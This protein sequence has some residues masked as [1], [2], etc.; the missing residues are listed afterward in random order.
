MVYMIK[1]NVR[2]YD[3][4]IMQWNW[5]IKNILNENQVVRKQKVMQIWFPNNINLIILLRHYHE[6]HAKQVLFLNSV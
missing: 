5:E 3:Q 2:G 4:F 6:H 1:K